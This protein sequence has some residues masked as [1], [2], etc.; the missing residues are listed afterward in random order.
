MA[1]RF[2]ELG[3]EAAAAFQ[4]A[5]PDR[6]A[7]GANLGTATRLGL[8]ALTVPPEFGG[9]GANLLEF[10]SYQ[11]LMARGDGATAL[12]LAMH[13][14]LVGGEAEAGGWPPAPWEELCAAAVSR[15]ALVNS[16]A[17]EPGAGTPSQA[18]L[19][20]TR[21]LPAADEQGPWRLSG[22]KTYTTGGPYLSHLRVS[23]RVA[24]PGVDAYGARFLVRLPAPG[25]TFEDAW[26]PAA[27]AGAAND[28]VVLD[29]VEGELLYPEQGRGCEGTVWFQVAIA[30][31]YLGIGFRAYEEV[32]EFSR[33]RVTASGR[34]TD[35]ET[36]RLRLGRAHAGLQ[37]ARRALLDTCREWVE[38]GPGREALLTDIGLA[39]VAAVNAAAAAAEE[40][41]RLGGAAGLGAGNVFARLLL[42]TRAG[43]SH[44]P[45]DDVAYLRLAE[46]DLG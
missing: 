28:D 29:D 35:R 37:A 8:P 15:G 27:L 43:L 38:A 5:Q 23:A 16:A 25:I 41:V 1:E 33:S 14:M 6:A 10:A 7:V 11:Q 45:L 19:P 36:V 26:Q 34:V 2:D 31:T 40:A 4:V 30:A 42:E 32:L 21:A 13:H 9:W 12:V 46:R 3:R 44:P 17:T 24:P 39:K 18:G 20:L 22:R